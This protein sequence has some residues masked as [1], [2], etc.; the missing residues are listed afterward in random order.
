MTGL[1]ILLCVLLI[2]IV[3]VQIG[4]VMELTGQIKGE[5]EVLRDNSKWNGWLS[6]VFMVLFLGGVILSAWAYRNEMMGFGPHKGAS[7]HG[8]SL[9]SLFDWT[10]FFTGIVFVITHIMLFW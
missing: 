8:D 10:L 5:L 6:L 1:I 9:D 2:T 3:L 4:K 7:L